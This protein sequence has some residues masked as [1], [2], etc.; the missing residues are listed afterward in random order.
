[1]IF[2][3]GCYEMKPIS[4][5]E[6]KIVEDLCQKCSDYFI[7]QEGISLFKENAK[8]IFESIPPN[9]SYKD[10]H[11][12]GIFKNEKQLVGIIDIV[13]DFPID[14]EWMLGLMV[15]EPSERS[16]GLGKIM[17][18]KLVLWAASLGAKSFRIGVI[19]DNCK[20]YKFWYSLGYRKFNEVAIEFS[21][22]TNVVNVMRYKINS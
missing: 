20:G 21:H 22:K 3:M 1:M 17:H 15:I 4:I 7:I 10:K 9:K 12:F 5:D 8:E 11:I 14:G 13:K 16:N 18:E 6:I 19:K 2:E